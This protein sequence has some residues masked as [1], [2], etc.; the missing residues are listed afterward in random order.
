MTSFTTQLQPFYV[1]PTLGG[2]PII[3]IS[4]LGAAVCINAT[5]GF[6]GA[7]ASTN[8]TVSSAAG[9]PSIIFNYRVPI[10]NAAGNVVYLLAT[11]SAI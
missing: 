8:V 3:A 2:T 6:P 7:S 10:L 9:T 5:V 1:Y 4:T 11:S